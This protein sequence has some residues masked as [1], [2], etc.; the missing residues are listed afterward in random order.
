VDPSEA[1]TPAPTFGAR[2]ARLVTLAFGYVVLLLGAALLVLPGPG[3]L[4]ILSG[5]AVVG[6]EHEWA[7]RV[8]HQL[9]ERCARLVRRAPSS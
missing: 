9:R 1:G 7:R 8:G 2:S 3:V 4:L 6:R 5:L